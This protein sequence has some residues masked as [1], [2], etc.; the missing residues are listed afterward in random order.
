[1]ASYT[2]KAIIR[3]ERFFVAACEE[4]GL[5]AQ[6][7][8]VEEAVA[9]LRIETAEYLMS[10]GGRAAHAIAARSHR[11]GSRSGGVMAQR[12]TVEIDDMID[13]Q[14]RE[15]SPDDD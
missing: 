6:G 11:S 12:Y 10:L 5:E 8:S 3:R 14:Q 9:C 4:L 13:G 7:R 2:F 1:M 15:G